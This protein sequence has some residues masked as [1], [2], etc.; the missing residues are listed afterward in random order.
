[1]PQFGRL[2][3]RRSHKKLIPPKQSPFFLSPLSLSSVT[4]ERALT[5]RARRARKFDTAFRLVCATL[6]LLRAAYNRFTASLSLSLSL[7]LCCPKNSSELCPVG[8]LAC[9]R[10]PLLPPSLSPFYVVFFLLFVSRARAVL[11]ARA[12]CFI[13]SVVVVATGFSIKF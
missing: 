6:A 1:M 7:S 9:V 5:T 3:R 2:S 4:S 11:L 8:A 12:A 13:P 10:Q